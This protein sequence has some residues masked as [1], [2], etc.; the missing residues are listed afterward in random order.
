[1]L[2]LVIFKNNCMCIKHYVFLIVL[3]NELA[4]Q[5]GLKSKGSRSFH[6]VYVASIMV[7]IHLTTSSIVAF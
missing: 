2:R 6:F 4:L 1:M 5:D 7:I 3:A